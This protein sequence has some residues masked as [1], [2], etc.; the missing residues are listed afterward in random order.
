MLV[1][2]D[3]NVKLT[4]FGASKVSQETTLNEAAKSLKGSPL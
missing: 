1:T 3:G 4:D 2:R